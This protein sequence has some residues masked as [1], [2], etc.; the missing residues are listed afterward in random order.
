MSQFRTLSLAWVMARISIPHH[1]VPHLS[2][3]GSPVRSNSVA[4]SSW[5]W[6]ATSTII[7]YG[8]C[9]TVPAFVLWTVLSDFPGTSAYV[10]HSSKALACNTSFTDQKQCLGEAN[11]NFLVKSACAQR[12]CCNKGGSS[13]RVPDF[14][15]RDRLTGPNP[16]A[17]A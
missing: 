17:L 9:S 10:C 12:V 7:F 1:I 6:F 16:H 15:G 14:L 2:T 13:L 4:L 11:T 5:K 8:Y 3:M